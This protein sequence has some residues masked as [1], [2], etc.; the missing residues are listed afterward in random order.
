MTWFKVDDGFPDHPKVED[1]IAGENPDAAIALWT[2]AGAWCARHLTDGVIPRSKVARLGV[3]AWEVGAAELVRVK[4]WHET[5]AGYRF[6]DWKDSQPTRAKVLAAR[7]ADLERKHG[8]KATGD[9]TDSENIPS[10]IREESAGT[11]SGIPTLPSRPGPTDPR[12]SESALNESAD[13][14]TETFASRPPNAA[15]PPHGS[16]KALTLFNPDA[17]GVRLPEFI[18]RGV[19]AGYESIKIVPPRET[20]DLLWKGWTELGSWVATKANLIGQ[21]EQE[22]ARHLMRCFLR[23]KK[24]NSLGYPIK[25]LRENAN[26]YWRDELP[27]E[28]ARAS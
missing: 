8:R 2:L 19:V 16:L 10:G 14:G 3:R 21:S 28:I 1:V 7:R 15:P 27:S 17:D 25:F 9:A 24:A 4:L 20:K 13:E 12:E 26:E 6:H 18:R 23:S 5:D 11:P 22:T